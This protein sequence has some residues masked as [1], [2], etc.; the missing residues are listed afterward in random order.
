MRQLKFREQLAGGP[1]AQKG[2]IKGA[3]C[4]PSFLAAAHPSDPGAQKEEKMKGAQR[5]PGF[6]AAA[7]PSDPGAQKGN[8]KG[9]Q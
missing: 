3:Q 4:E 7:H 1:P 6:L 8:M 5:E 9:T 2:N